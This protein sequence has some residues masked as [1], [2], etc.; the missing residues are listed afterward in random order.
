MK[1]SSRNELLKESEKV[2]ENIRF[3]IQKSSI[4]E[5]FE[6]GNLF[7]NLATS[8]LDIMTKKYKKIRQSYYQNKLPYLIGIDLINRDEIK[9]SPSSL[10]KLERIL[11]DIIKDI[12]SSPLLKLAIKELDKADTDVY[13]ARSEMQNIRFYKSYKK[14]YSQKELDKMYKTSEK[15]YKEKMGIYEELLKEK[16]NQIIKDILRNKKYR[17]F[18][19]MV[20]K[21]LSSGISGLSNKELEQIKNNYLK[22]VANRVSEYINTEKIYHG[23]TSWESGYSDSVKLPDVG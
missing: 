14:Q 2:L 15:N 18:E 13:L 5:G 12:N 9:I 6:I 21:T 17:N 7:K 10:K 4:D 19:E 23:Q 3:K 22:V 1:L 20:L 8:I 11:F 16:V